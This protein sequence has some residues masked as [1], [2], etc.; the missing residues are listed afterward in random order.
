MLFLRPSRLEVTLPSGFRGG[1]SDVTGEKSPAHGLASTSTSM[2][3]SPYPS[4]AQ[5]PPNWSPLVD[6][7]D[8]GERERERER[9][10]VAGLRRRARRGCRRRVGWEK[11]RYCGKE[12]R[13]TKLGQL[14]S[15]ICC[16]PPDEKL[17]VKVETPLIDKHGRFRLARVAGSL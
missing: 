15:P 12:A 1:E 13:G 10:G 16:L 11:E 8:G 2:A 17:T 3:A 7:E 14:L 5:S 4:I 9:G 6:G